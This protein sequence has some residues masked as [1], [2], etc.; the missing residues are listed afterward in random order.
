M[1][2]A[3]QKLDRLAIA[4]SAVCLVHCL[5]LPLSVTLVP[6]LGLHLIGHGAFH[7]LMLIVVLPTSLAAFGLGCRRHGQ[8]SVAWIGGLGLAMLVVASLAVDT[9][10]GAEAERHLTMAGG[11]VLAAAHVLNFR[12]CRRADC[13]DAGHRH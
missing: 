5:L 2:G 7:D 11:I 13:S 3:S 1:D 10:W 8:G 6:I 12:Y 4:F 9:V